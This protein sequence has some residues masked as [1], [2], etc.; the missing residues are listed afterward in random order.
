MYVVGKSD[1]IDV[2]LGRSQGV[3]IIPALTAVAAA[4]GSSVNL[5]FSQGQ[6]SAGG[7]LVMPGIAIEL[8]RSDDAALSRVEAAMRS[9]ALGARLDA[10]VRA[11]IGEIRQLVHHRRRVT[12]AWH[13]ARGPGFVASALRGSTRP[14]WPLAVELDGITVEQALG[15]LR[16]ALAAEGSPQLRDALA[17]HGDVLIALVA[18]A[19]SAGDVIERLERAGS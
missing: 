13:R 17:E 4:M 5:S 3:F 19:H 11:H 2:F 6:S 14:G 10:V 9:T 1:P 12:V 15:A 8:D 18:G 7:A 16:I